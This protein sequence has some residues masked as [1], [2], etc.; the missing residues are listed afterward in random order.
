[1]VV[2]DNASPIIGVD[3]GNGLGKVAEWV[4]F[5]GSKGEWYVYHDLNIIV[6]ITER[7][8]ENMIERLKGSPLADGFV[9]VKAKGDWH[10]YAIGEA[11]LH[12]KFVGDWRNQRVQKRA[13]YRRGYVGLMIIYLLYRNYKRSHREMPESLNVVTAHPP[14]MASPK[15]REDFTKAVAGN[16]NLFIGGN[17]VKTRIER[18]KIIDEVTGAGRNVTLTDDG[19]PRYEEHQDSVLNRDSV[20]F[21]FGDG[22][23]DVAHMDTNGVVTPL[24]SSELGFFR[25]VQAFADE[26][27]SLHGHYFGDNAQTGIPLGLVYKIFLHPQ[28]IL[29][30]TEWGGPTVDCKE[31]FDSTINPFLSQAYTLANTMTGGNLLTAAPQIGIAGGAGSLLYD[32]LRETIFLPYVEDGRDDVFL[33]GSQDRRDMGIYFIAMGLFKDGQ[34]QRREDENGN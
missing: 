18:V 22:T 4:P 3:P 29:E 2:F 34:A 25:Y 21:D 27:D 28:K 6:D 31:I 1:M 8:Y 23:I 17:K 11:A 12:G 14:M 9:K 30:N 32:T 5:H 19:M 15:F 26:F 16:W 33:C 7:D 10:F 13:K 24:D 20:I